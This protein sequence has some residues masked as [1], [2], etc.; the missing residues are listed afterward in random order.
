MYFCSCRDQKPLS[1]ICQPNLRYYVMV[2][3]QPRVSQVTQKS[4]CQ[5][6]FAR[7]FQV[8][9]NCFKKYFKRRMYWKVHYFDRTG[10]TV[11]FSVADLAVPIYQ[12]VLSMSLRKI[13]KYV[14]IYIYK[15]MSVQVCTHT[16]THMYGYHRAP[17][18]SYKC[19][20][21]LKLNLV[22]CSLTYR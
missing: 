12:L 11:H 14:Y 15:Y 4:K 20:E 2:C 3:S 16:G 6:S 5:R 10:I 18:I 13:Y 9:K 22:L 1:A 19:L 7:Y 17:D 8:P 21:F